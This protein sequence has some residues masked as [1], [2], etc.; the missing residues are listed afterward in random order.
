MMVTKQELFLKKISPLQNVFFILTKKENI[1]T[2]FF[3]A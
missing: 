1:Q 2:S 3:T